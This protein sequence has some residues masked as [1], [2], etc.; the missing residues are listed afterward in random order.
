MADNPNNDAGGAFTRA[1]LPGLILGLVVGGL[2]GAFLPDIL[3]SKSISP[4]ERDPNS[5]PMPREGEEEPLLTPEQQEA[6][7]NAR[8]GA[9]SLID[10]ASDTAEEV[11][12]D[13]TEAVEGVV[14]DLTGDDQP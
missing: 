1:F 14:D 4:I 7:D 6:L 10:D 13:T 2:A 5:A 12:D 3:G 11:V 8:E 9:E